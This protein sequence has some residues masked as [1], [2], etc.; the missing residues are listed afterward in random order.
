M[1]TAANVSIGNYLE[2]F[3]FND[4]DG[5]IGRDAL[6]NGEISGDLTA[7]SDVFFDIEN[8]ADD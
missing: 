1:L 4:G 8:A 7:Q 5:H 6:I 3:I 2:A